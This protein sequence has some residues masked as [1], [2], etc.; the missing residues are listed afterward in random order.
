MPMPQTD[1]Q[2]KPAFP[3]IRM[4]LLE[5]LSDTAEELSESQTERAAKR[6]WFGRKH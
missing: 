1:P 4:D 6:G 3:Q 2:P 5:R